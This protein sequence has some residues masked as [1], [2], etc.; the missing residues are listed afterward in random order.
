MSLKK[1]Y[2]KDYARWYK[3]LKYANK[4]ICAYILM[5]DAN[6]IPPPKKQNRIA[7]I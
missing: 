4:Y 6:N 2:S 3:L 5:L 1:L 7:K